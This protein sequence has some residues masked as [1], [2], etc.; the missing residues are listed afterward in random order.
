MATQQRAEGEVG[1]PLSADRAGNIWPYSP[2]TPDSLY[3]GYT[4]TCVERQALLPLQIKN[5]DVNSGE[6]R[7][8]DGVVPQPILGLWSELRTSWVI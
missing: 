5:M 8:G 7:Y 4:M 6:M 3:E 2:S 1:S